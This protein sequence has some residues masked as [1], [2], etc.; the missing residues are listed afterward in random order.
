M[1]LVSRADPSWTE[2]C[3]RALRERGIASVAAHNCWSAEAA[4]Q[5]HEA[6]GLV[7]DGHI[8]CD[9][10]DVDHPGPILSFASKN[11]VVVYNAQELDDEQRSASIAHN[12]RLLEGEAIDEIASLMDRALPAD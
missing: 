7:M 3:S 12:A 6:G 4:Q 11:P 10:V 1:V 5:A 8:L 2:R 9:F